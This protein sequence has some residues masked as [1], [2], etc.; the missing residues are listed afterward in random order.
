MRFYL[1]FLLLFSTQI[2]AQ[3]N[4]SGKSLICKYGKKGNIYEA[5]LFYKKKYIS[6]YLFLEKDTYRIRNN[7]KRAYKLTSDHIKIKPFLIDKTNLEV[8]DTEFDV[9]IGNCEIYNNHETAINF[10]KE[11][12]NK[13]QKAIN[14]SLGRKEI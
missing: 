13:M 11:L 4:I 6:K 7:E 10:M 8:L 3:N 14:D 1:F 12:S 5:Y 2:F 9:I